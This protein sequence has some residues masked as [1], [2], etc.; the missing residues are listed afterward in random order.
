[1][2]I[3]HTSALCASLKSLLQMPRVGYHRHISSS[4]KQSRIV[5]NGQILRSKQINALS[6]LTRATL[7]YLRTLV[8]CLA[9]L[10]S[11]L[12]VNPWLSPS[13]SFL[14]RGWHRC[15]STEKVIYVCHRDSLQKSWDARNKESPW[16]PDLC[17]FLMQCR[18]LTSLNYTDQAEKHTGLFL[19]PPYPGKRVI[20]FIEKNPFS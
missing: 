15:Y 6:I 14:W 13:T 4:R 1:M 10:F 9:G 17:R 20:F 11:V 2:V 19:S 3:S 5:A 7:S 16:N 18:L 12:L 8:L